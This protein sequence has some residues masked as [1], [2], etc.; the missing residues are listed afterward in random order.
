MDDLLALLNEG[1]GAGQKAS[2]QNEKSFMVSVKK[3]MKFPR[4]F[5]ISRYVACGGDFGCLHEAGEGYAHSKAGHQPETTETCDA[6]DPGRRG[7]AGSGASAGPSRADF[8]KRV[9]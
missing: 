9:G 4:K 7:V 8:I 3:F 1:F 2:A 6:G 5:L